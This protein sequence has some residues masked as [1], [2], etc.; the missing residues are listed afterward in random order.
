[1]LNTGIDTRLDIVICED[2]GTKRFAA[3]LTCNQ[4]GQTKLLR[5]EL[6]G[7]P[8]VAVRTLVDGLQKDTAKLFR[9]FCVI[10]D[11]S[12]WL[13]TRK[14]SQVRS[15]FADSRPARIHQQGHWQVRVVG[16]G[17]GEAYSWS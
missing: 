2:E 17:T 7:C 6:S 11:T 9:T 13:L 8:V 15:G 5:T 12:G 10:L 14:C 1:M 3:I 4:D 16:R